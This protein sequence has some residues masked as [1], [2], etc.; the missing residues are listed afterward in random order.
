MS[1]L[2]IDAD[3]EI[4]GCPSSLDIPGHSMGNVRDDTLLSIWS[5]NEKWRFYRGGWKDENLALCRVC[6]TRG[7]CKVGSHCRSNAY[8]GHG[9]IMGP[10]VECLND[11]ESLRLKREDV[12]SYLRTALKEYNRPFLR[13]DLMDA[14]SSEAEGP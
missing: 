12:L 10:P 14:I 4:Y 13:K 6:P 2:T 1:Q 5:D 9:D 3:G 8:Q 11:Y 7:I